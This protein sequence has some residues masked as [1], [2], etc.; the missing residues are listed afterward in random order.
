TGANIWTFFAMSVDLSANSGNLKFYKGG[1]TNSLQLVSTVDFPSDGFT[2]PSAPLEIGNRI[3]FVRPFDGLIDNVRI[4]GSSGNAGG[5]LSMSDLEL[6]RQADLANTP[7][8]EP[9][10]LALMT[11]AT[12]IFVH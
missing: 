2:S 8:P 3:D 10:M 4:Y 5:V 6:I 7:V 1:L 9:S 11:C 12:L